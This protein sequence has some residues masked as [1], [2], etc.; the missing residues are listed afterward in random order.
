MYA[1]RWARSSRREG[2]VGWG[3]LAGNGAPLI[4]HKKL[5][6][7]VLVAQDIA[8]GS[9]VSHPLIVCPPGSLLGMILLQL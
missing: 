3:M 4:P 5:M 7:A 9:I 6:R 8:T 1:P 2:S